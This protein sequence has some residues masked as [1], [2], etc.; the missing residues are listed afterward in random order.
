MPK[1]HGNMVITFVTSEVYGFAASYSDALATN[2]FL[3]PYGAEYTDSTLF[4]AADLALSAA[5]V[6]IEV[7]PLYYTDKND[8][9]L[10]LAKQITGY[11]AGHYYLIAKDYDDKTVLKG[12]IP[13]GKATLYL[14]NNIKDII[15]Y[16]EV[17]AGPNDYLKSKTPGYVAYENAYEIKDKTTVKAPDAGIVKEENAAQFTNHHVEY[18]DGDGYVFEV[19]CQ[20]SPWILLSNSEVINATWDSISQGNELPT[21]DA[22]GFEKYGDE[23]TYENDYENITIHDMYYAVGTISV[24]NITEGL[25][26]SPERPGYPV[27][28]LSCVINNPKLVSRVYYGNTIRDET[29]FG[30]TFY[31]E[32]TSNNWGPV[33]F[34]IAYAEHY[35]PSNPDGENREELENLPLLFGNAGDDD[36]DCE[37]IR[38]NFY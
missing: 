14:S 4:D 23:Y 31:P 12:L 1:N 34:V 37:I 3:Q 6:G 20:L 13:E 21:L 25:N 15:I 7:V 5:T 22:W 28:G 35:T 38:N 30:A 9:L 19:D 29:G 32:M 24:N 8:I 26:F 27:I 2:A 18:T 17:I 11:Q 33:P 36:Y 10:N 16:S